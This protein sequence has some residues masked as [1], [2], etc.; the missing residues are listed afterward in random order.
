MEGAQKT[1]RTA[2]KKVGL[3][4]SDVPVYANK[5][6]ELYPESAQSAAETLA[7][8]E[9]TVHRGGTYLVINGPQFSTR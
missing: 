9:V 7:G 5:T 6:A 1:F 4:K 3:R 8:T 2:L